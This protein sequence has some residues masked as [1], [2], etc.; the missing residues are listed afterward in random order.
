MTKN[1][2]SNQRSVIVAVTVAGFLMLVSTVAYRV[3][4]ARLEAPVNTTS[5]P[6]GALERL[7]L[8]IGGW[9]GQKVPLDEEIVRA[10]DTEAHINRRYS[11]HNAS[12]YISLYVSLV[13]SYAVHRSSRLVMD[14]LDLGCF[15]WI[16]FI[17]DQKSSWVNGLRA[18]SAIIYQPIADIFKP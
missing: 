11:R 14:N 2:K 5:M 9:T 4:A 6:P 16:C 7:P 17:S 8:Q 3:L 10:T 18:I 1:D 13:C 12:E 15:S